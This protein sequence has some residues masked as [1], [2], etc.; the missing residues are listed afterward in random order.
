MNIRYPHSTLSS[1]LTHNRWFYATDVPKKR[2]IPDLSEKPRV[3]TKWSPFAPRDSKALETAFQ[4]TV[5]NP[6]EPV[7]T[8][9]VNE[10]HLFEVDIEE[11]ELKPVYFRASTYEVRRAGWF[12][13][14]GSALKPCDESLAA[15]IEEGYIK[16]KPF[17]TQ[18]TTTTK[19]PPSSTEDR[20]MKPPAVPSPRIKAADAPEEVK[21]AAPPSRSASPFLF[22]R[23]TTP[24]I[25]VETA[26]KE[27]IWKLLGEQHM[28]K[29]V[30]YANATTAWLLSDDMY[31]KL[32]A[33]VYQTL[34]AGVHLGGL[35]LVRG[36][37]EPTK[38]KQQTTD[39]E[40]SELKTSSLAAKGTDSDKLTE[41]VADL[42][43]EKEMERDYDDS[44]HEDPNR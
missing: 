8:V 39:K 12:F 5:T 32:T 10:D 35:K 44:D 9:P 2:L 17:R 24:S 31:G 29:Y 38:P 14:E 43:E 34:S 15:Q 4:K 6:D 20:S 42:V 16:L 7:S 27:M 21:P 25:P 40:V 22:S 13:Q 23:S 41:R 11:R 1:T 37:T 3:P 33:S 18:A 28:G 36:Y 19:L 26:K 30:V